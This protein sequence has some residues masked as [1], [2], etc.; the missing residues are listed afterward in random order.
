MHNAKWLPIAVTMMAGILPAIAADTATAAGPQLNL[1]CSAAQEW[2]DLLARKYEQRFRVHVQV[3]QMST[4]PALE[5]IRKTSGRG[6][7]DVWFGGTGDPHLV[8]ASEDL[9]LP[10]RSAR[11]KELQ[12]WAQRQASISDFR[13]VG[14]YSGML[15]FIVNE[16]KL[17]QKNIKVPRCWFNLLRPEYAGLVVAPNPSS[18]GTGYT[19]I[20]TL[21]SMMGEEQAFSYM[22][23][24]RPAVREYLKSGAQVAPKVA[25]GEVPIAIGFIHEGVRERQ[26]GAP[27]TVVSPC[28]GTGYETG[29][30]SIVR[31]GN[32]KEARRFVDWVLAPEVQSYAAEARQLQVPSNRNTPIPLGTPRFSD[33]KIYMAYD[34]RK[35]AAPEEKKR[36]TER[37]EKEI[38]GGVHAAR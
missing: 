13:T 18:S 19:M 2:C 7:Y 1:L 28:E 25:K 30:V 21:V 27:V 33:F 9:T 3:A 16:E 36:L 10:Y 31:G 8:A 38:A 20:A 29:S 35:F 32:A 23:H 26:N 22:A 24:I 37:W 15:G 14:I 6:T 11:L 34:P 12:D 5:E 4:N 17:K